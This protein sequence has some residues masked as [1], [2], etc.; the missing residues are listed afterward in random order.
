MK[1][2]VYPD[3]DGA[4]SALFCRRLR[5]SNCWY[6]FVPKETL[7]IGFYKPKKIVRFVKMIMYL[8]KSNTQQ[9]ITNI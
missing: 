5:D 1:G 4:P 2:V 8:L 7:N 3:L 9:K 6:P